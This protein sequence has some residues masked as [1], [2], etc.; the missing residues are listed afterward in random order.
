MKHL[1]I[2]FSFLV[3]AIAVYMYGNPSVIDIDSDKTID[4]VV[5]S[6]HVIARQT[7]YVDGN[8]D[9]VS[10]GAI[11]YEP[12]RKGKYRPKTNNKKPADIQ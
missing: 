6:Y 7:V 3:V 1:L 12:K 10:R 2:L 5:V 9:V 11:K 8:G 4:D